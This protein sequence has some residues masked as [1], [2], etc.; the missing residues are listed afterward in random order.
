MATGNRV[1]SSGSRGKL[2]QRI[3]KSL[4]LLNDIILHVKSVRCY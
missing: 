1:K 2:W 3:E 4:L